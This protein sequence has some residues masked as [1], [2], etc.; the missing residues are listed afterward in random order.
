MAER[1][2]DPRELDDVPLMTGDDS[3]QQNAQHQEQETAQDGEV[4]AGDR[5]DIRDELDDHDRHVL[6]Q[7]TDEERAALAEDD[8]PDGNEA[9]EG[10]AQSAQEPAPEPDAQDQQEKD[11][12]YADAAQDP[13]PTLDLTD[14]DRQRIR[15]AAKAA[16]AEARQK[17]QDGDLTDED[18]EAEFDKA[19]DLAEQRRFEIIEEKRQQAAEAEFQKVEAAF[20]EEARAY[21]T[22]DYPALAEKDHLSEFDRHVRN[23]TAS[24]R[25]AGM[26]PRQMLEAAH[27]LYAAEGEVL[28]IAVPPLKGAAKRDS[29]PQQKPRAQR[30]VVPTLAKVPAAASNAAA[31]GEWG[32][33]EARFNNATTADE[34]EAVIDSIKDPEKREAFASM[35]LG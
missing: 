24:P 32:S 23:V 31:D 22:R 35:M 8:E 21:L 30:N 6:D 19:D 7:L 17:W 27:R 16:R 11:G 10:A 25:Y 1:Q 33:L 14:E 9:D 18:L 28:G 34:M 5:Y 3:K 20:H 13:Q 15:E 4:D 29:E 2:T 12:A 26:S